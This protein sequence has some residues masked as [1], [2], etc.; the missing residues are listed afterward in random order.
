MR[1]N[2][3]NMT[4]ESNK[5]AIETSQELFVSLEEVLPSIAIWQNG[6][7]KGNREIVNLLGKT[8]EEIILDRKH[9][10][11]FCPEPIWVEYLYFVTD[12]YG[13]VSSN[14]RISITDLEGKTKEIPLTKLTTVV[15]KKIYP[16]AFIKSFVK[17]IKF[18]SESRFRR[19]K[20]QAMHINGFSLAEFVS[21]SEKIS[22]ALDISENIEKLRAETEGILERTLAKIEENNENITRLEEEAQELERSN[23]IIKADISKQK[24]ELIEISSTLDSK[25]KK[26]IAL[27]SSINQ[28]TERSNIL[29]REIAQ[30]E[31]RIK[32]LENNKNVFS[33]EF[34]DYVRASKSHTKL[35]AGIA[36]IPLLVIIGSSISLLHNA[37]DFFIHRGS[38]ELGVVLSELLLRIPFSIAT[39]SLAYLSWKICEKLIGKCVEIHQ[40]QRDLSK[41]L[42]IAKETVFSSSNDLSI[43]D[44]VK[45]K[46]R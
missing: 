44:E 4:A 26:E 22:E 33:D 31:Q 5:T 38:Y 35:Y 27:D 24:S 30:S 3:T 8:P 13:I 36:V 15:A 37:K 17:E 25:Q 29:N 46:E 9:K 43:S 7:F 42:V 41:I 14:V 23:A 2:G 40:A 6:A 12:D 32:E 28:L 34:V 39:I 45:F 19:P 21:V 1:E 20:I 18:K 11:I 10:K 16:G